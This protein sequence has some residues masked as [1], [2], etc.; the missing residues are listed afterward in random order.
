LEAKEGIDHREY[1]KEGLYSVKRGSEDRKVVDNRSSKKEMKGKLV[2]KKN[3]K[4]G[5]EEGWGDDPWVRA[6]F[7]GRVQR[8]TLLPAGEWSCGAP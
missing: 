5:G 4:G 6:L 7:H 3:R 1:E 2:K 8:P